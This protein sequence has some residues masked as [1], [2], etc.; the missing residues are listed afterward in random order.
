MGRQRLL[1]TAAVAAG[2]FTVDAA[3]EIPAISQYVSSLCFER[4]LGNIQILKL[5]KAFCSTFK[6]NKIEYQVRE[7]Y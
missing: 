7:H 1:I 6:E 3:Y 2:K 5:T 4:N